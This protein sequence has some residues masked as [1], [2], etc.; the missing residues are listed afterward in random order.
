MRP[1]ACI[2][3]PTYNEAENVRDIV[4]GIFDQQEKIISH[5]LHVLVVDDD[6]PDR[7]QEVVRGLMTEYE[8]LHLLT[9]PKRGLGEAYKRGFNHAQSLLSPDLI[10]EMDADGQHDPGL[11]PLIVVLLN[12][13][14][15]LVIGSRF[16]PG[17]ST[18]QFSLW[19][20]ASCKEQFSRRRREDFRLGWGR[21][22]LLLGSLTF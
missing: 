17:G 10:F 5:D 4:R 19:R 2:V 16:V 14:F 20:K 13:G 18:P 15:S 11:I 21:S 3:L 7:T 8:N 12:N 9:G 6:S 22:G 1:K